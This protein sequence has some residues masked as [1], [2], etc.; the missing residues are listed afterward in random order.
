M[1]TSLPDDGKLH[2]RYF[3]TNQRTDSSLLHIVGVVHAAMWRSESKLTVAAVVA[4]L[5]EGPP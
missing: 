1:R 2:I 4:P 5:L 3:T